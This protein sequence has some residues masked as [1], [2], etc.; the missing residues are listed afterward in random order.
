[1]VEIRP[2][3]ARADVRRPLALEVPVAIEIDG[4]GYAVMMAT[5]EHLQD[6]ATGFCLAERLIDTAAQ[7]LSVDRHEAHRGILL[8]LSLAAEVR[9]RVA[10]RA[11]HRV[12]ESSCGLCGIENLEQALRPLPPVPPPA[13]P[14]GADAVFAALAAIRGHQ[15]LGEETGAVHAAALCD[16]AGALVLA[17]EDVGRHNAFDKLVGA[18]VRGGLAWDDGFA[19]VTARLSYEL[20]EK[21]ALAGCHTLVAISAPTAL[22]IE[23]AGEAGIRVIALARPD[24]ALEAL[25][26][27]AQA[28]R[29]SDPSQA[30]V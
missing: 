11:R 10:A 26:S 24:A 3:G 15:P 29:H 16:A 23:R 20:V 19:L 22:A 30:S 4:I 9:E 2:D 7:L 18:M 27:D 8:R 1:M 6:F 28:G 12:A 13:R 14:V 5:P 21:A 25:P 17:R